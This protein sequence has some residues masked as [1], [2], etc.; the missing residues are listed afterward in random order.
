MNA[1]GDKDWF[2]GAALADFTRRRPRG[3][4]QTRP[5]PPTSAEMAGR[6]PAGNALYRYAV[7]AT[8]GDPARRGAWMRE[9]VRWCPTWSPAVATDAFAPV[10]AEADREL[11]RLRQPEQEQ[12]RGSPRGDGASPGR[13]DPARRRCRSRTRPFSS[14]PR[15]LGFG[16]CSTAGA[17]G[18]ARVDGA[19]HRRFW[20]N[21]LTGDALLVE[22]GGTHRSGTSVKRRR[23]QRGRRAPVGGALAPAGKG[24][25]GRRL[26]L[27]RAA[28]GAHGNACP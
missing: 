7:A 14:A 8:E 26:V 10:F 21:N 3:R 22:G 25:R 18:A 4:R 2:T 11:L 17:P 6:G 28:G 9:S 13:A 5:G 27:A 16:L 24:V 1:H 23:G 15:R 19:R 12:V 20:P